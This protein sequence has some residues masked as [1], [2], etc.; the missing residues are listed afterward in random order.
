[1]LMSLLGHRHS[2]CVAP[3]DRVSFFEDL[4]NFLSPRLPV[5]LAGDFNCVENLD[6]D[7]I[8]CGRHAN[9]KVGSV[10]LRS[11]CD[12]LSLVDPFRDKNPSSVVFTWRN[13]DSSS[14]SRIDRFYVAKNIPA[15]INVIPCVWSDHDFVYCHLDLP[16]FHHRGRG[17]WKCN[18]SVLESVALQTE[19]IKNWTEWRSLKPA[20]DSTGGWWDMAKERSK[21]MIKKHSRRLADHRRV[22]R[23]RLEEELASLTD[24]LNSG[25]R[26]ARTVA[27]YRVTR[28]KVYNDSLHAVQGRKVRSRLKNLTEH[29][30]PSRFFLSLERKN[31]EKKIINQ[32]VVG[33]NS[34]SSDPDIISQT[35]TD[36]Y[37]KLFASQGDL[38]LAEQN[39]FL[40]HIKREVP[41]PNKIELESQISKDEI[42]SALK[43]MKNNKSPGLDGLSKEF[44]ITFWDLISDDLLEVVNESLTIGLLPESQ[45][46]GLVTLISKNKP[47]VDDP[48]SL[49]PRFKRPIS[50]LNVDYK[51][52]TKVLA[53]RLSRVLPSILGPFQTCGV[54]GRSIHQN[55]RILRDIVTFANS[56]NFSSS[57]LSL[58]QEKAFDRVEWSFLFKVLGKMGF[59]P[60][61]ISYIQTIYNDIYSS[62]L[63]NGNICNPFPL[64]RG[65]RQG[66]PLSP[67]LYV[68]FME[69]FA[70]AVQAD[71]SIRGCSLPGSDLQCKLLQYADDT[72]A[73]ITDNKSFKPLINL[74][75]KFGKASGSKLNLSKCSGLWLGKWRSRT[76]SPLGV[77]WTSDKIKIN[78]V[79]FG[80]VNMSNINWT[81]VSEK[82]LSILKSWKHRKLSMLGKVLV[83]NVLAMST[84]WFIAPVFPLPASISKRMVKSLFEFIW[85]DRCEMVKRDT[86]YL[87]PVKGGLNLINL[88]IKASALFVQS[89]SRALVRLS[90][91]G[92]FTR[93]WA[94]KSIHNLLSLSW[95]NLSP[96]FSD[97]PAVQRNFYSLLL[98][99]VQDFHTFNWEV[100]T[101]SFVYNSLNS[102]TLS[103]PTVVL[104][105]PRLDW[106]SIFAILNNPLFDTILQG[107]S[108]RALHGAFGFRYT[109]Y[110]WGHTRTS[111]CPRPSCTAHETAEHVF[112]TCP[113]AL[114][115]WSWLQHLLY[116]LTGFLFTFDNSLVLWGLINSPL[117]AQKHDVILFIINVI[118]LEL[119]RT[120][121]RFISDKASRTSEIDILNSVKCQL[122][123]RLQ[124]E[125]LIL[126]PNEMLKKWNVLCYRTPTSI[127]F[128]I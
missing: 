98:A 23:L 35:Y 5:V 22:D 66:C 12:D 70:A 93:A 123:L 72:T 60:S 96:H 6:L 78:G 28:D 83:A 11:L 115:L 19:L 36:F 84:L 55:I 97:T 31:G 119:W 114:F 64:T 40:N 17:A 80:D 90:P 85:S 18:V 50:L 45:R 117:S 73:I 20:F 13:A 88:P 10:Q 61:F 102:T 8:R 9:T 82:F 79:W 77:K 37:K 69:P 41:E 100:V 118:K 108:W 81:L 43:N 106:A 110:K 101:S 107:F 34:V 44:Y 26:S 42:L 74:C 21:A 121:C 46:H 62:L 27:K 104:K 105:N 87:P 15:S 94:P 2:N 58:D 99:H 125:L 126:P 52:L 124:A 25:D 103:L 76:D 54:P 32:V 120:R 116:R 111:Q 75:Q 71:D 67:L 4:A 48:P 56:R 14:A 91:G 59:G 127:K 57:L 38:D 53:T 92:L 51:V 122:T 3:G 29:E 33:D 86:F 47:S 65:V 95:S 30:K 7:R 39:Y 89:T 128:T 24:R 63:I 109:L 113:V 112:V 68:I 1:M 16:L 49:H